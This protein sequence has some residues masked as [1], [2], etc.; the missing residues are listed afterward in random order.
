[1]NFT[2]P[3]SVDDLETLAGEV[4]QEIPEELT[5]QCEEL[6]I[7]VEDIVD[8]TTQADLGLDD[9]FE[10]AA[11]YRSGKE[12]SPGIER[13]V[14]HDD[15]VL[16]LYRRSFLDMWCET[17]EDIQSLLRNV[18]IEE[19]GRYFEFSDDDIQEMTDQRY[20]GVL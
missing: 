3:P 18:M 4:F 12:I 1:M 2:V 11:L 13:K 19:L 17:E 14:A 7:V 6:T 15:D 8:E 10:L 9:P 20:Q 5:R 16:V